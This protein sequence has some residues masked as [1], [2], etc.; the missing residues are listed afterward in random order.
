VGPALARHVATA[1]GRPVARATPVPGGSISDA[2]RVDLADGGSVFAK[3]AA[4]LPP[5]LLEVE[6]EG[7]AWLA[8]VPGVRVPAVLARTEDVL[9]TEWIEPGAP[10]AATDA[11]LGRHLALLHGAPAPAFGWHRDGF[12]G[13]ERQR[14]TPVRDD[15]C[16]FWIEYRIAPL[17]ERAIARGSLAPRARSLVD[18]LAARLPDLAGPPAAPVRVHG[19][20]W[21]GNVHV[22]RDGLT[23]LVDPAPYAG[24]PEVDLAMLHLFGA[25]GPATAAAYEDVRPLAPGW[26]ERLPI[27]QLEPLLVHA[28]MFGGGYGARALALLDRFG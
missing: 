8:E 20:L 6:A 11:D 23:W 4:G 24:H 27:W 16:G 18:R 26:R 2:H 15:W 5:D 22:D 9:V 3:A 12:I 14:N 28:A 19:D 21:S 13:R 1:L 10:T 17:A 7:L 25:P